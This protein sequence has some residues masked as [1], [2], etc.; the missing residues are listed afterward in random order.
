VDFFE[1][2]SSKAA[3]FKH[4][5]RTVN[6]GIY[7]SFRDDNILILEDF[8]DFLT[9]EGYRARMSLDLEYPEADLP[10]VSQHQKNC[11]ASTKLRES[12]HIHIIFFFIEGPREHNVNLSAAMEL[13]ALAEHEIRDV[14]LLFEKGL[15][16]EDITSYFAGTVE[17]QEGRWE[18]DEFARDKDLHLIRGRQFCL[19]RMR[20]YSTEFK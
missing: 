15:K 8:R 12:S 17:T 10:E 19:N 5:K 16:K 7:G 13:Q 3:Y 4:L 9:S 18:W 2:I 14:L 6:I 1:E 20:H 11:I